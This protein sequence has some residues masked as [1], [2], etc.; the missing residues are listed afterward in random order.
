MKCFK[1]CIEHILR[2]QAAGAKEYHVPFRD[3]ILT[4]LC[5]EEL[6]DPDLCTVLIMHVDQDMA[7]DTESWE[8]LRF[9]QDW[10]EIERRGYLHQGGVLTLSQLPVR[11]HTDLLAGAGC[12]E[13]I[14]LLQLEEER[15]R[16]REAQREKIFGSPANEGSVAATMG[17]SAA[18]SEQERK[19]ADSRE[20]EDMVRERQLEL[21][22]EFELKA[23]LEMEAD[24]MAKALAELEVKMMRDVA[25]DM[26]ATVKSEKGE[27]PALLEK[28]GT[29]EK[30]VSS[31][32]KAAERCAHREE[33]EM[34][35]RKKEEEEAREL[36]RMIREIM[37]MEKRCEEAKREAL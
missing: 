29:R 13:E 32:E 22:R 25:K 31:H 5:R 10:M 23:R 27:A 26:D 16:K 14:E 15:N 4:R 7:V 6:V 33:E 1:R 30:E 8:N 21:E 35:E 24:M 17:E 9:L 2:G 36:E 11:L 37:E 20:K 34:V 19:E 3:T 12:E 18:S 28:C